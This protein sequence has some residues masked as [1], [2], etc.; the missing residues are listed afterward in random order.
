MP[1]SFTAKH[2]DQEVRTNV[3]RTRQPLG[4]VYVGQQGK[5][6]FPDT[7]D[8]RRSLT[9]HMTPKQARKLALAILA[10]ADSAERDLEG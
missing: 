7:Q 1:A 2:F 10:E 6:M 9:M 3:G 5:E 4:Y 8:T